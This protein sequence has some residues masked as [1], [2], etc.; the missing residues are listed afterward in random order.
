MV[1]RSLF[2]SSV[3]SFDLAISPWLVKT[4]RHLFICSESSTF[5]SKVETRF[6]CEGMEL[7]TSFILPRWLNNESLF[8]EDSDLDDIPT[9]L[10]LVKTEGLGC[11]FSFN[12][13]KTMGLGILSSPTLLNTEGSWRGI[14]GCN[15]SNTDV[16]RLVL[17][18]SSH[19]H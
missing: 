7:C 2:S 1:R 16:L 14:D 19:H 11:L 12:L 9:V 15:V 10:I 8:Y 17:A 13:W 3:L 4:R 6:I 18:F 5:T